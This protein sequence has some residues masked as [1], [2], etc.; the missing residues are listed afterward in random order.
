M[1]LFGARMGYASAHMI[2]DL[3]SHT[4][5]S[6]GSLEPHELIARAL[7]KGVEVLSI[8]DHDTLDAYRGLSLEQ[9][10]LRLVAG[11]EFSTQ[12]ESTG[13]HVLGLDIDPSSDAV[14][15]GVRYQTAARRERAARIGEVLQKMGV[16]DA[17]AG[18]EAL[19]QGG[20]IGRPH[21]AR[22]LVDIGRAR[23]MEEAFRKFVGDGKAGDVR[24]HWADLPQVV[25]WIREAGGV[26]VLAHPLKYKMTRTRLKRLLTDFIHAGGQGMEV[27]SGQQQPQMTASMGQL[28][29]QMKLLASCG[30]DFHHPDTRWAELG[31]LALLPRNVTPVWERFS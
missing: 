20:Y 2:I 8:T 10:R 13:I 7:E 22:Y 14:R 17:F 5:R 28:C 1:A 12:W 25:Q 16:P 11:I 18:A 19:S 23:S 21:F 6:D 15:A 30:S 27:I 26:A 4:R 9:G 31:R 29:E 3:H 24:Q